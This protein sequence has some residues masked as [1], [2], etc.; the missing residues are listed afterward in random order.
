MRNLSLIKYGVFW[1]GLVLLNSCSQVGF[2]EKATKIEPGATEFRLSCKTNPPKHEEA[3]YIVGL[4]CSGDQNNKVT[5]AF[6]EGD[7]PDKCIQASDGVISLKI[8]KNQLAGR[9]AVFEKV[10]N[11]SER[12]SFKILKS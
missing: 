5:I 12:I 3:W 11:P 6:K 4:G 8:C 7:G 9:V 2:K 10:F 1:G